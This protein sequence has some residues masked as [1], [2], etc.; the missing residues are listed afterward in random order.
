M[1]CAARLERGGRARGIGAGTHMTAM[2]TVLP[3]KPG[4]AAAV[5]AGLPLRRRNNAVGPHAWTAAG[6]ADPD[7]DR[8]W[9]AAALN[10]DDH[11]REAL[12]RHY[13]V[14]IYSLTYRLLND[15][16]DAEDATQ[17]AFVRAFRR[18]AT[19]R[20][21]AR[22]RTW[23]HRIAVN[24]CIEIWRWRKTGAASPA[25]LDDCREAASNGED[26]QDEVVTREHSRIV[27]QSIRN[28]PEHYRV[29]LILFHQQGL[30]YDDI[31]EILEL[32]V[33]TVK[34]RLNR[35]REMLRRFLEGRL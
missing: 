22:F 4:M 25:R 7:D 26:P 12:V 11:A 10:G 35:G 20:Q 2:R 15:P 23:L 14:E 19:F 32:P 16:Q 8:T 1:D 33:A 9:V 30:A 29:P 5:T 31:A 17:D 13:Y 6:W 18:L 27:Q 28:L 24:R 34:T 21:G 3:G